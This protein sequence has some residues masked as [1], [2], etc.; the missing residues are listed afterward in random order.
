V[1]AYS[2]QLSKELRGTSHQILV[3]A[4]RTQGNHFS[5]LVEVIRKRGYRFVTL[6]EALGDLIYSLPDTY[7]GEDG[8]GG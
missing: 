6:E 7:V 8:T 5:E 3:A 1:F 4:A 2:E